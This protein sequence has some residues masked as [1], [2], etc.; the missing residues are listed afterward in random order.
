MPS[1]KIIQGLEQTAHC[2]LQKFLSKYLYQALLLNVIRVSV[3]H[4]NRFA[5]R[6]LLYIV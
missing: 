5:G 3:L 2:H 6:V 4:H 1:Q